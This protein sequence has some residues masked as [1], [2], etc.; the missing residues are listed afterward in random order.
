MAQIRATHHSK[1]GLG[2][3]SPKAKFDRSRDDRDGTCQPPDSA[4]Y[5]RWATH[6]PRD[7]TRPRAPGL[8]RGVHFAASMDQAEA[9]AAEISASGGTARTLRANLADAGAAEGLISRCVDALGAPELLVNSAALFLD[10]RIETLEA[11]QWDR[12]T[13]SICG[14]PS[15]LAKAFS[16]HLPAD[17]QGLIINIIDQRVWRLTPD[18]FS[19]T[20]TKVGLYA[21]TQTLAQALAPR[22]RVNAIGPGPGSRASTR[23]RMPSRKKSQEL[24]SDA[25]PRPKRSPQPSASSLTRRR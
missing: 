22:I 21:A 4:R 6:W 15:L 5:G 23:L 19:Y 9:V 12:S 14:P 16:E 13:P 11:G 2:L 20:I 1:G 18:F 7:R 25:R 24:C 3:A 17:R 10:D 8:A